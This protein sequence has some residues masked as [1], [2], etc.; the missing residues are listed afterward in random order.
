MI[1]VN[2][3]QKRNLKGDGTMQTE[4]YNQLQSI[5]RNLE[6]VVV[7]LKYWLNKLVSGTK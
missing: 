3:V 7:A 1:K 2:C 4:K 5:L 6:S